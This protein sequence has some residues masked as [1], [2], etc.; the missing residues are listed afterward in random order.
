MNTLYQELNR[1][2]SRDLAQ[3]AQTCTPRVSGMAELMLCERLPVGRTVEPGARLSNIYLQH[4]N[5]T[6]G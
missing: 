1:L 6:F 3:V 2:T 5:V 4:L